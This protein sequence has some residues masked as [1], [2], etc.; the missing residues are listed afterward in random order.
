[1]IQRAAEVHM[2][3][4]RKLILVP[5]ETPMSTLQLENLH[6]VASAGAVVLPAM[7]GWYHGV[8]DLDSLVDFVVSRILDQL[9]VDNKLMRRWG[10]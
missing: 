9:G 3:E 10:E 6:R 5:R 4:H 8:T 1:L 7:P 2:K